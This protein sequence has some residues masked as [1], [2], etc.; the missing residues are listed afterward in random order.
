MDS[1]IENAICTVHNMTVH[2]SL[3]CG[4]VDSTHTHLQVST[5]MCVYVNN[6]QL[7]FLPVTM[8]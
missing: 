7:L 3:N 8:Y 1:S 6:A 4:H 2:D 5:Y